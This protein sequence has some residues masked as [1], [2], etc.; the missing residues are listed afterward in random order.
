MTLPFLSAEIG[1]IFLGSV[2]DRWEG[3]PPS[4]IQKDP[5]PGP[6]TITLTGFSEDTQ[7]DLTVHGGAEKA[8]HHYALDH[9]AAWQ[10]EGH[11]AAGHGSRGLWRKHHDNRIDREKPLHRRYPEAW[12]SH[13]SNQPG[14][15]ALLEAGPAHRT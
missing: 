10:D 12:Y 1:G 11:M 6:Q 3:K 4:A 13:R 9:Y 8:I 2:Q 15:S 5:V 7:A 14:P